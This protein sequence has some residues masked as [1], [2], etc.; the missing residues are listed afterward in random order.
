MALAA[1]PPGGNAAGKQPAKRQKKFDYTKS[2]NKG[3]DMGL[4]NFWTE[5]C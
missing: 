2:P 3:P 4:D 1:S 5:I